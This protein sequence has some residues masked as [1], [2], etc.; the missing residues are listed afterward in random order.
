MLKTNNLNINNGIF[1]GVSY[2]CIK[3]IELKNL[4]RAYKATTKNTPP[5]NMNDL[6]LYAIKQ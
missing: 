6:K 3:L 2:F 4:D 1:Q 5:L